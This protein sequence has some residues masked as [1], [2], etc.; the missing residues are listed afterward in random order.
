MDLGIEHIF[1]ETMLSSLSMSKRVLTNLGFGETEVE[2]GSAA[3]EARDT[4]LLE[5]QH[6]IYHSEEK[7]IQS[8]KDTASEFAALLQGDVKR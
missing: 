2:R 8:A 5:E 7:L 6:A 3:F 4:Q 1:R